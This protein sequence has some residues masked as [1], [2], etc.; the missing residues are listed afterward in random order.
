M[1]TLIIA[2]TPSEGKLKRM[3]SVLRQSDLCV[4]FE[5]IGVRSIPPH[6]KSTH[7]S[8]LITEM[9]T[10]LKGILEHELQEAVL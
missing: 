9:I 4:S 2:N 8:I 10:V 7:H 6:V 1:K 3:L 5:G